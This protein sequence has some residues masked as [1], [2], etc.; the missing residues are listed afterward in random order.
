MG[1][2]NHPNNLESH[3]EELDFLADSRV[4]TWD[5]LHARLAYIR[6]WFMAE[7][8]GTVK[9]FLMPQ[10]PKN[11]RKACDPCQRAK[12]VKVISRTPPP[13]ATESLGRLYMG[14]W[15][16]YIVPVLGF[17]GAQYFFTITDEFTRKKWMFIVPRRALFPW[18]FMKFKAYVKLQTRHKIKAIRLDGARE[19]H[20][21][22]D[23]LAQVGV[24]VEYTTAYTPSQNGVA[25]RLNRTLVAM[26][27][28]ML[29]TSGLPQMFWGF[30]IE[31]ACY[32]RNRLS[33][34][35]GKGNHTRAG[36]YGQH[37]RN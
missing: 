14:G 17:G 7:I 11:P 3:P 30:A 4:V 1:T 8:P 34:R 18:E 20:T 28:A 29:F 32:I 5:R 9:A 13:P 36:S 10:R 27:K 12:Q 16:P 22:R 23:M 33:I 6:D 35:P 24:A 25:E 26:A 31:A 21:L 37:V 2:K 19:N 15:G